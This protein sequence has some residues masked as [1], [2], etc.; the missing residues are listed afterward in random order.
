MLAVTGGVLSLLGA[1]G[2]GADVPAPTVTAPDTAAALHVAA[3]TVVP[4]STVLNSAAPVD[5]VEHAAN[6]NGFMVVAALQR[7]Q[8]RVGLLE[9]ER[10][11]AQAQERVAHSTRQ[12]S[13]QPATAAAVSCNPSTAGLGAVKP[14]VRDAAEFLGCRFGQPQ[15]GGVAGRGGPSDHPAGLAV[16]FMVDRA[17]GDGLAECALRNMDALG[18]KYV[19][20]RQR[21]NT[22]SGWKPM[23]D[24]GGA[25]ANHMDH[26]HVSFEGSPGSGPPAGC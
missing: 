6:V 9:A 5:G 25:T 19:I 22:G 1:A 17:T 7:A 26:V 18:I 23:E 14:W 4:N 15:V 2:G 11:T 8:D 20:W 12:R 21:I 24:R 3:D 16:D 10:A 13:P